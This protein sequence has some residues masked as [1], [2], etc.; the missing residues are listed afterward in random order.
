MSEK[1][2]EHQTAIRTGADLLSPALGVSVELKLA[3]VVYDYEG[4]PS[5]ILR[6]RVVGNLDSAP[7]TV[8]VKKGNLEGDGLLYET[9]A[10]RFLDELMTGVTPRFFGLD[11]EAK[12]LVM[13]DL[14]CQPEQHLGNI[15]FAEDAIYATAAL[16]AFHAELARMHLVTMGHEARLRQFQDQ[17]EAKRPSRH[18]INR[19]IEGLR[20]LPDNLLGIG[21]SINDSARQN[22]GPGP[23]TALVHGDATPANAFYTGSEIRL[24]D[25]ETAQFRHALLDGAYSRLRYLHSVWARQI[26]LD[27]QRQLMKDYREAMIAGCPVDENTFDRAFVACCAG[28]L[29]GLC[30]FIPAVLDKDRKWG[31]STNRQRVVAGLEHFVILSGELGHF[32]PLAQLCRDAA[33]RLC[34][35]WP[36]SDCTMRLYPAFA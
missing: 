20:A 18:R 30:S 12:V 22:I 36:E 7:A 33:Q 13:E 1:P 35:T 5:T 34:S 24:F 29:A 2:T 19:I 15:L 10:L 17:Y 31:R 21:V 28:W 25:L 16:S 27:V 6:C 9:A 8:I 32:E 4:A 11:R 3:E 14:V 23:F 26:P